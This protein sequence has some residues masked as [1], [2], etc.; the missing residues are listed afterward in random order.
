MCFKIE[1]NCTLRNGIEEIE[2]EIGF[3]YSLEILSS[4]FVGKSTTVILALPVGSSASFAWLL[5]IFLSLSLSLSPSV[6]MQ[7]E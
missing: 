6:K 7:T 3:F 4:G 5:L 2:S 1:K